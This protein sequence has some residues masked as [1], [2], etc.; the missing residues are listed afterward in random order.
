[1]RNILFKTALAA[2]VLALAPMS[3]EAESPTRRGGPQALVT[4]DLKGTSSPDLIIEPRYA[5]NS[6]LPGSGFCGPWNGGNPRVYFYVRNTGL[7]PAPAS[8]AYVFFGKTLNAST[9]VPALDAGEQSLRS[10]AIPEAAWGPSPDHGAVDFLIAADHND[11]VPE[12]DVTNNYGE[13][14]CFGPAS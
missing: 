13:G 7:E 5:G 3:A 9:G 10:V 1:M 14:T 8:D 11:D 6:G 2:A 12:D 4:G